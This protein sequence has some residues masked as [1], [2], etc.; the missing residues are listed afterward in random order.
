M[1]IFICICVCI[2]GSEEPSDY[3]QFQELPETLIYSL[4]YG[5]SLQNGMF[6]LLLEHPVAFLPINTLCLF[7][8]LS[9]KLIKF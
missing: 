3:C 4:S 9:K 7:Q 6:Y 8:F 5:P 2:Y 1:Y